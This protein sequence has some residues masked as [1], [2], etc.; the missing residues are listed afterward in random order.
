MGGNGKGIGGRDP[1]QSVGALFTE[2]ILNVGAKNQA[3]TGQPLEVD[4]N[5][6]L[7]VSQATYTGLVNKSYE[8]TSFVAGDSPA[9]I[10]FNADAGRNSI[11]GW[12]ICDGVGDISVEISAD[13]ATFGDPFTMKNGENAILNNFDIDTVRI[14]HTGTDSAYRVVLI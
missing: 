13:G 11:D 14:S 6:N 2:R 7:L 12:I 8:D 3:G 4:V 1:E 10:D 9:T 5:G